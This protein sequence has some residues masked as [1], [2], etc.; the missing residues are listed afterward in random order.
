MGGNSQWKGFRNLRRWCPDSLP[1]S[2]RN[3]LFAPVAVLH[4]LCH[5]LVWSDV[6]EGRPIGKVGLGCAGVCVL[7]IGV[8]ACVCAA[9]SAWLYG[10][11]L[12]V[13][14]QV[15]GSGCGPGCGP[16]DV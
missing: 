8:W 16:D 15:C 7:E 5:V 6:C 2:L 3:I 11:V 12:G 14:L 10:C 4:L 13:W 1:Q 9:V